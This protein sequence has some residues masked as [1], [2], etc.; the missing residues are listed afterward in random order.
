MEFPP[1]SNANYAW[2]LHILSHLKPANG[3]AGFLFSQWCT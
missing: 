1:E 2:I 3:V